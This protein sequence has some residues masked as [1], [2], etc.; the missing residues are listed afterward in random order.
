MEEPKLITY[1]RLYDVLR[2]GGFSVRAYTHSQIMNSQATPSIILDPATAVAISQFLDVDVEPEVAD[3]A[4]H[5][6]TRFLDP[7]HILAEL[8]G[9][10]KVRFIVLTGGSNRIAGVNEAQTH[11]QALLQAG[12][13]RENIIVEDGS[14]NTLENVVF[15]LPLLAV[16]IDLASI[17]AITVVSKWYHCRRAMMTLKRHLPDGI[18]YFVK[19]YEPEGLARSEWHLNPAAARRVL[20]EWQVIPI[21]LE[22][23][24]IEKVRRTENCFV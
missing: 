17:R 6:G 13:P 11:L 12:V 8:F 22:Q 15:A 23:G 2:I 3:L 16:S 24:H 10:D 19:S 18:R 4:F 21:Y 1:V 20:K 5:F 14:T 9:Q 7:V